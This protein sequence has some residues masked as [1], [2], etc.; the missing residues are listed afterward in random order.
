MIGSC[1]RKSVVISSI[2][3]SNCKQRIFLPRI[4]RIF[5]DYLWKG[6]Q[7]FQKVISLLFPASYPCFSVSSVA[8]RN[9][10]F[11]LFELL[12]KIAKRTRR[13]DVFHLVLAGND[14]EL[15][16]RPEE[17]GTSWGIT[18]RWR[19]VEPFWCWC[20]HCVPAFVSLLTQESLWTQ[21]NDCGS[22]FKMPHYWRVT[23]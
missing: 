7:F 13:I 22:W 17:R 18:C 2:L 14:C 11:W 19:N 1:Q 20:R 10:A 16:L 9:L 21:S 3:Y 15:S 23:V 6:T 4:T 5:T 8:K 12:G